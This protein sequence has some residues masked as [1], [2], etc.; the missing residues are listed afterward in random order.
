[1]KREENED[2]LDLRRLLS[3]IEGRLEA[4]LT[5]SFVALEPFLDEDEWLLFRDLRLNLDIDASIIPNWKGSIGP[6]SAILLEF[7]AC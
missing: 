1:M 7:M 3:A 4:L 6:E 5:D 2:K